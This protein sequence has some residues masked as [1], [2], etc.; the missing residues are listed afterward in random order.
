MKNVISHLGA[1]FV[2]VNLSR[3]ESSQSF[4]DKRNYSKFKQCYQG[5]M[6]NE[7]EIFENENKKDER[8]K[9]AKCMMM[10]ACERK[11]RI[12]KKDFGWKLCDS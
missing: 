8:E 3:L 7:Q 10:F 12:N 1:L 4:R 11:M 6:T 5:S 9:F 2:I